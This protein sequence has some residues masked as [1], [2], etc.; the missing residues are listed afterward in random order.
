M[1]AKRRKKRKSSVDGSLL[2]IL[3]LFAAKGSAA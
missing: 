1:A 3:R 2:R